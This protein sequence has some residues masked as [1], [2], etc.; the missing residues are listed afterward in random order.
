MIPDPFFSFYL[1][2][3]RDIGWKIVASEQI[4]GFRFQPDQTEDVQIAVLRKAE[5]GSGKFDKYYMDAA[6]SVYLETGDLIQLGMRVAVVKNGKETHLRYHCLQVLTDSHKLVNGSDI[7]DWSLTTDTVGRL[8]Q[9]YRLG[10]YSFNGN[11]SIFQYQKEETSSQRARR[12]FEV[13]FKDDVIPED[14]KNKERFK[15]HMYLPFEKGGYSTLYKL[16]NNHEKEYA[17]KCPLTRSGQRDTEVEMK[18]LARLGGAPYVV[19]PIRFVDY[20]E[21]STVLLVM[22]YAQYR[23][24]DKFLEELF[25][26]E[27]STLPVTKNDHNLPKILFDI[28]LQVAIALQYAHEK[29]I[30][31]CD[32]KPKNILVEKWDDRKELFNVCISDLNSSK[33]YGDDGLSIASGST[34]CWRYFFLSSYP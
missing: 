5:H 1:L 22:P 12:K 25:T 17:L 31:H 20:V 9:R 2:V 18:Q 19:Y 11:R 30:A 27:S 15:I 21:K 34:S 32:L 8:K 33:S 16:K 29:N 14:K 23:D 28:I 6:E 7:R 24:L 4:A 10:D 26:S 3:R 13:Q